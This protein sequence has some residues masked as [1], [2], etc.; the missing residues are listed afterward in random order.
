MITAGRPWYRNAADWVVMSP[1][2]LWTLLRV[3]RWLK[4]DGLERTVDRATSVRR[5]SPG[6]PAPSGDAQK[7]RASRED[8][9]V[10]WWLVTFRV[11]SS[12]LYR[13]LV[14]LER[15]SRLPGLET[16]ELV[17][18]V[19]RLPG[20]GMD[21]HSWLV[22]NGQD[23]RDRGA[24]EAYRVIQRIARRPGGSPASG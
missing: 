20:G 23:F 18:G 24:E 7:W 5:P 17:L 3:R 14:M 16:I 6:A 9:I 8:E 12:C 4:R 11:R 21:A 1:V 10:C 15:L 22:A 2:L 13:S 19:R